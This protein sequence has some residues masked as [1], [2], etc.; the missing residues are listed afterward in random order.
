M[1][2]RIITHYNPPPHRR[3]FGGFIRFLR[4][5]INIL[6][7]LIGFIIAFY[8]AVAILSFFVVSII[9]GNVIGIIGSIVI[10]LIVIIVTYLVEAY[11]NY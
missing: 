9:K 3:S 7:L 5:V 6:L 4:S 1:S 10:A 11:K 2:T 8:L